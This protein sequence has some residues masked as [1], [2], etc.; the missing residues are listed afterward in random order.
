MC[1]FENT[2]MRVDLTRTGFES[3]S[4]RMVRKNNNKKQKAWLVPVDLRF[5]CFNVEFKVI[6]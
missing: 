2:T 6:F 4:M 1:L 3:T 5:M